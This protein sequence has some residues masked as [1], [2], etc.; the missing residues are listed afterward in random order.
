MYRSIAVCKSSFPRNPARST[1]DERG[2]V[3]IHAAEGEYVQPLTFRIVHQD[4]EI[5]V[6][7]VLSSGNGLED[8]RVHAAIIRH[9]R[10]NA[11][12][13]QCQGR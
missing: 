11:L 1:P 3:V 4:I 10:S 13:M 9:D 5:A 6:L 2:Y 7:S 12:P 8:S